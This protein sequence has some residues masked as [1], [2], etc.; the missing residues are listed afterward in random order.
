VLVAWAHKCRY[1]ILLCL[2]SVDDGGTAGRWV[3]L[4]GVEDLTGVEDVCVDAG[5]MHGGLTVGRLA[6]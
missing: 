5:G 3:R 2:G 4:A 6:R 1:Y